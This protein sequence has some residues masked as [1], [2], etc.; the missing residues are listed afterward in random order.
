RDQALGKQPRQRKL[1]RRIEQHVQTSIAGIGRRQQQLPGVAFPP[2][3]LDHFVGDNFNR[4]DWQVSTSQR[5]TSRLYPLT[6]A[7]S[8]CRCKFLVK[9]SIAYR[10]AAVFESARFAPE[11]IVRRY[12]SPAIFITPV[13][14]YPPI[15][16]TVNDLL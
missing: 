15:G 12:V 8:N 3:C 4:D 14:P 16:N 9:G 7:R 13:K 11:G 10:Y 1:C 5:L 2:P 6:Q